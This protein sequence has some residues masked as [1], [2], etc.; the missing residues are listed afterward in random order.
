MNGNKSDKYLFNKSILNQNTKSLNFVRIEKIQK[1]VL[2]SSND[3][4]KWNKNKLNLKQL[5]DKRIAE[6]H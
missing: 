1:P 3:L 4:M 2:K 6:K 5:T